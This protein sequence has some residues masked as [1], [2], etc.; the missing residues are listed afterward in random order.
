VTQ[1]N[2]APL[3]GEQSLKNPDPKLVQLLAQAVIG[4]PADFSSW[5]DE[6]LFQALQKHKVYALLNRARQQ[7]TATGL[8]ES[9]IDRLEQNARGFALLDLDFQHRTHALLDQLTDHQIPVLLIKGLP[10]AHRYY[11]A[12]HLRHRVDVD[13]WVSEDAWERLPDL[14]RNADLAVRWDRTNALSSHQF[15][16]AVPGG[17]RQPIVFDIHRTLSN[18]HLFTQLFP[19][20]DCW[21]QRERLDSFPREA[22]TLDTARQLILTC[23]HRF[24]HGRNSE[25]DRLSWL[26]DAHLM[27]STLSPEARQGFTE[28]ALAT[29]TGTL[30]AD[31]LQHT[32]ALFGTALETDVEAALLSRASDEP[33]ASL[34]NAGKLGWLIAALRGQ[35][36]AGRKLTYLKETLLNQFR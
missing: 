1:A 29:G 19:F 4:E 30:C 34:M 22:W 16:A 8:G 15:T 20:D 6:P 32:R 12:S 33:A 14:L 11:P 13:L 3:P 36:G 25:R 23:V 35:R 7:G 28:L 2:T 21:A 9:S 10:I 18:R 31:A 24:A 5:E 27:F 17:T 26:L